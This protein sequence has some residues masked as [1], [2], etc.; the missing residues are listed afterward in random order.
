MTPSGSPGIRDWYKEEEE[1]GSRA[2][3]QVRQCACRIQVCGGVGGAGLPSPHWR[4]LITVGRCPP[5]LSRET[6]RL[7]RHGCVYLVF[8]LL[9]L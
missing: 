4:H 9:R 3:D 2:E 8:Y 1:E 5:A 6:D 7:H